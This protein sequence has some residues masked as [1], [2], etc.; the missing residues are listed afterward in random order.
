MG[1]GGGRGFVG[2]DS[3]DAQR[4]L[5]RYVDAHRGD[6]SYVTATTSWRTTTPYI[7]DT[8]Q[9]VLPMGGFSGTVP[10]STVAAFEGLVRAGQVKFVLGGGVLG[11][12][13]GLV[14]ALAWGRRWGEGL[15]G[16]R[17]RTGGEYEEG[18]RRRGRTGL[19]GARGRPDR[20][21]GA[22]AVR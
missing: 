9:M 3:L 17:L 16:V 14:A 12:G 7:V 22:T 21:F 10:Q 11:S 2:A 1:D 19:G 18:E 13:L 20:A 15:L 5:L 4:R 8:G 6:A